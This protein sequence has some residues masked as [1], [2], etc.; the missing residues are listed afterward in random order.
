MRPLFLLLALALTACCPK[1]QLVRTV[2]QSDTTWVNY[3][4]FV[5]GATVRDTIPLL[6]VDTLRTITPGLVVTRV[7]TTGRA[8]LRWYRDA[9]NRLVVECT[10]TEQIRETPV[11]H[12][13]TVERIVETVETHRLPWWVRPSLAALGAV[14]AVLL[15]IILIRR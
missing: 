12:P 8:Q 1:P 6:R 3:P 15:V 4:V 7:D 10:A 5:P 14:C 13:R 9:Y 11:P 2:T